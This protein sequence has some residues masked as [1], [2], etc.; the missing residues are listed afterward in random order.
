MVK[1]T[2]AEPREPTAW[3]EMVDCAVDE[4]VAVMVMVAG[5]KDDSSLTASKRLDDRIIV[6]K[7]MA[8]LANGISSLLMGSYV[9]RSQVV[10]TPVSVMWML[11]GL[12][13]PA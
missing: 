5:F 1:S 3:R 7:A 13:S 10:V 12:P 9:V 2:V 11:S 6:F 4:G 8:S